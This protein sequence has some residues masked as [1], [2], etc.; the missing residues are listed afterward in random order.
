VIDRSCDNLLGRKA[1]IQS[2]GSILGKKRGLEKVP[3]F[4]ILG[5][6]RDIVES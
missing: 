2:V 6:D 3:H 5:R 1:V 4:L